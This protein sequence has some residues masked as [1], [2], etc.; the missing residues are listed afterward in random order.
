[1]GVGFACGLR[2]DGRVECWGS[3][4]HGQLGKGDH[5]G[6]KSSVIVSALSNVAQLSVG[7]WSVCAVRS[8][9]SLFCWGANNFG[10][11]G[12]GTTT[13]RSTPGLVPLTDVLAV[14][15]SANTCAVTKTGHVWCWGYNGT[16]Q[17]G[18]GSA[19]DM[20]TAPWEVG[21]LEGVRAIVVGGFS[22]CALMDD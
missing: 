12:D 17:V 6:S 16:K 20:V 8:D 2:E 19:G 3:N 13:G 5:A 21:S 10:Q 1:L 18:N 9:G 22:S 4:E 7:G 15:I 11:L 14:S